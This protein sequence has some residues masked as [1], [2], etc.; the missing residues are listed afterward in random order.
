MKM[1]IRALD[2]H[3]I[4]CPDDIYSLCEEYCDCREDK[5]GI[6]E[7]PRFEDMDTDDYEIIN[8]ILLN[9]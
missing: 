4:N 7:Q 9:D 2:G 3:C 5:A 8:E 6:C 1:N